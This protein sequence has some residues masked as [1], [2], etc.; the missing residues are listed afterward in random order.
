[1][2]D[3]KPIFKRI[4][5]TWVKQDAFECVSGA[6]VRISSK[7]EVTEDALAGTWV[8]NDNLPYRVSQENDFHIT[9]NSAGNTYTILSV[10]FLRESFT[11]YRKLSYNDDV[12]YDGPRLWTN[13]SFKTITITSKL[14][15]VTDGDTL[16]SWLQANATKQ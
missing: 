2:S 16:L 13:E 11:N 8:F 10:F 7:E 15:E 12:V 9:F 3:T 5:G 4:N 14:S 1:M 6:W